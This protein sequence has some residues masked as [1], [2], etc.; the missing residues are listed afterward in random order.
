MKE[1]KAKA[2]KEIKE[3]KTV[4][5]LNIIFRRYLGKKGK[6]AAVFNSLKRL[7]EKERKRVGRE[8]NLLKKELK[9]EIEKRSKKLRKEE[10][11]ERLEKEKIDISRP[12]LKT[13]S[14]HLHPL[15]LILEQVENIFQGMGF[16]IVE[17]PEIED[18]WHNFDAL[19]IPPNHPAR[20]MWDTFWLKKTETTKTR[21]KKE[22]LLLRTHTSPIQIRYMESHNP[23]L[24][25]LAPG[26]AFRYEAID[27]SH[28]IN[29]YQIEGLMVGRDVSAAN[30]KAIITE[31]LKRFFNPKV[32]IRLR[33][34]YFP[35]TEP[36]FEI[37]LRW[38]GG[39]WL[40]VIAAGMVHPNVF[41]A[42]GYNP[43]EWQGFAFGIG[44]DRLAMIK[45]KIKDIRLFYSGDLRFLKQF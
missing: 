12:G 21:N 29:F 38:P 34:S 8:A 10:I 35:F 30:F 39:Q 32:Q 24:R 1:I 6:L 14:G 18:E 42:S 31:F 40:E 20:D 43:K 36:S 3:S 27:F 2:K 23:P 17:G 41:L 9:E 7:S 11:N 45:Y 44:I 33:P 15:T 37:D 26:R 5:E 25:I 16:S 13:E 22:N 19:N 28:Q 4:E